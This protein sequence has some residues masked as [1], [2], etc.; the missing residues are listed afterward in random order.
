MS[1]LEV[2]LFSAIGVAAASGPLARSADGVSIRYEVAGKGEPTVVLVH[3]WAFDRHL[4]DGQVP[5]LSARRRVVTLDLGGHGESGKDRARWTMP[6]FGEDVKA[7][8]DAVGAKQVILV[9]HSMGGPVV[10][11]AARRLGDRVKGLVLVDTVLDAE[12]RTPADQIEAMAR[13]LEADY[14]GTAPQ[15]ANAYLFAPAT[16]AAVRERV[17]ERAT[18]IDPKLAV[19]LLRE[20]WAYDPLPALREIKAP[21]RAVNADK[22]PTNLEANRRHMPG[23]E[24]VIVAGSGHY[25]MLE[26]PERFNAA[27]D[28]ALAQVLAARR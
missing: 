8:V 2:A 7:V 23:Y 24:A 20:V 5:G 19:T 12:L 15:M 6:A 11:E 13:Q 9:G 21:I 26:Q 16:P 25:P 4:W 1:R 27:L 14:R 10:L 28:T 3:G 17:L 22:F 18:A